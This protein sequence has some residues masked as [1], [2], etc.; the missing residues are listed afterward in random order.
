MELTYDHNKNLR[1][2]AE[3]KIAF[4]DA[5]NFIWATASIIEDTRK[6]YGERRFRALGY[7]QERLH[8]LV[9]T[10]RGSA[11]HVISLRKA[12]TREIKH[13]ESQA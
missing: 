6:D 1:N 4:N 12:N 11:I 7:I 13:Y 2:I 10:P 8:A 9:F 5:I 3:R